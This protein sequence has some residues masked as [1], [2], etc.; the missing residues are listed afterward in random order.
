VKDTHT[1]PRSVRVDTPLWDA[2]KAKAATEGRTVS[3]V[4]VSA[5]RRYLRSAT[6]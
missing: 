2:V 1:P 5:L 3:D 6:R 4:V